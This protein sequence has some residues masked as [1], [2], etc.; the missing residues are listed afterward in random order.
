MSVDFRSA[1]FPW[2]STWQ[3]L[4]PGL[5][6]ENLISVAKVLAPDIATWARAEQILPLSEETL[7]T[8]YIPLAF[9]V[10][11]QASMCQ[12]PVI[13]GLN[14]AQGSGKSTLSG[15]LKL[16][17]ERGLQTPTAVLSLDDLYK[18]HADR[19]QMAV[20]THPLFANRG[21]P[22]THDTALGCQ[23]FTQLKARQDA[24]FPRFDKKA[25]QGSGDRLPEA[26]WT[27]VPKDTQVVL[28]EGWFVGA[29]PLMESD[30]MASPN[31]RETLEDPQ[32]IWRQH[33]NQALATDYQTLFGFLDRLIVLQIP[34][35]KTVYRQREEQEAKLRLSVS[36][37]SD[38]TAGA[39]TPAQ[40][41]NFIALFERLTQY[42]L[43]TLP[44]TA[45][46]LFRVDDQHQI[47]HLQPK[48][49]KLSRL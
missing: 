29:A 16:I 25:A 30:L 24:V 7:V 5:K 20:K 35:M 33:W 34:G 45:D 9:W 46:L 41:E 26:Q 40:V 44:L 42:Q 49:V 8:I 18:S 23:A 15:L 22:G 14:G 31:R 2:F 32:G 11:A 48:G 17:L 3:Q 43:S 19:Q 4:L 38:S 10:Q 27:R 47:T 1:D 37:S 36:G 28:F 13:I 6:Q 21:V 12:R 39:M